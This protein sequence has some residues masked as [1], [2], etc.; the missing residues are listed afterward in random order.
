M[1]NK[2]LVWRGQS[3]LNGQKIVLII[4]G[5]QKPSQN[6]KTGPVLQSYILTEGIH[7]VDDRRQGAKAICGS[8]PLQKEV[9]Y[10]GGYTLSRVYSSDLET[11]EPTFPP[12]VELQKRYIRLGS[13]GDP[14]AVPYDV[15]KERILNKVESAWGYTHQWRTCDRRFSQHCMASVETL[16]QAR[17]AWSRG[18]KTYRVLLSE[19][20]PTQEE[21]WCPYTINGLQCF[22][23]QLC[24]PKQNER[25]LGIAVPVHGK[26]GIEEAYRRL[27]NKMK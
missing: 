20:E 14:A 11:T 27:R 18:W 13:Y 22:Q 4:T 15:W 21:L 17:E 16:E 10:V 2:R 24:D 9:C 12:K 23:C 26:R 7:P 3:E 1:P 5:L 19:E 8:C 6:P 25:K